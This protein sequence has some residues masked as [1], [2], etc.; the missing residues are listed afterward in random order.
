M[1]GFI[2]KYRD[3]IIFTEETIRVVT[4]ENKLFEKE[5]IT[6]LQEANIV[7]PFPEVYV[8]KDNSLQAFSIMDD[9]NRSYIVLYNG[10]FTIHREYLMEL[11]NGSLMKKGQHYID[12]IIEYTW[13][14]VLLHEYGHLF[15]GHSLSDKHYVIAQECE[16][17][18]VSADALIKMILMTTSQEDYED[19]LVKCFIAIFYFFKQMDK[20]NESES[21]NM[22]FGCNYYEEK[23]RDHPL[24]VQ[25]IIYTFQE[26][27]V[28]TVDADNTVSNIKNK[29]LDAYI[30]KWK[31]RGIVA[32]SR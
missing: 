24:N 6:A 18:C 10:V 14:F 3:K 30:D 28:F 31:S 29:I 21:Y 23:D 16:A 26:F 12:D 2:E 9:D 8:F 11:N 5:F 15:C 22:L 4:E 27:N 1:Q 20:L 17:D 19:E 32:F 7:I 13:K 25:R